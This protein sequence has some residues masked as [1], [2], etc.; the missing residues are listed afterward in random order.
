MQ[1]MAAV[2]LSLDQAA[3]MPYSEFSARSLCDTNAYRY[4]Q[5]QPAICLRLNQTPPRGGRLSEAATSLNS[6]GV[7]ALPYVVQRNDHQ[8]ALGRG[9]A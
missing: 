4:S 5:A 7:L 3:L 1:L 8:D 9:W 2:R 6:L